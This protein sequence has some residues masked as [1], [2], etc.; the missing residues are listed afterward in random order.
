MSVSIRTWANDDLEALVKYAD[1]KNIFDNMS[2][3]FPHPYT[4]DAGLKFIGRAN[5]DDPV[6]IFAILYNNEVVGSIGI[7]PDSDI[8]R[9]NAAIAYWIAE[10]Y[11]G[12]GIAPAAIK[13]I[14]EYGFATFDI[15]RVYAKPFGRNKGSRRALEKAGFTHEATLKNTVLKNGLYLDEAIYSLRK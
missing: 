15:D 3:G 8:Y 4:V 14:V 5:N 10:P 13:L 1:N 2:D 9:K 7:F 6:K 11:W 12:K